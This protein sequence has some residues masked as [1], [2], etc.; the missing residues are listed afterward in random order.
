MPAFHDLMAAIQ[1]GTG[2]AGGFAHSI[3]QERESHEREQLQLLKLLASDDENKVALVDPQDVVRQG[4]VSFLDRLYGRGALR[5]TR[6]EQALNVGGLHFAIR[7]RGLMGSDEGTPATIPAPAPPPQPKPLAPL[8]PTS[9]ADPTSPA[10]T[11][12]S[13]PTA[14]T[15]TSTVH[16]GVRAYRT[17]QPGDRAQY[18]RLIQTYAAKYN[19]PLEDAYAI[20]AHESA[21]NQRA[22]GKAGEVGLMQLT[23]DTAQTLGVD[24]TN[25]EQNIEGGLRYYR[26]HLDQFGGNR[27]LA[28][29][30]YNA[31]PQAVAA[32]GNQVPRDQ[33]VGNTPAYVQSV[34]QAA[35]QFRGL[36]AGPGATSPTATR[37]A[38]ATSTIPEDFPQAP[39]LRE[40]QDARVAQEK[41]RFA[42]L[43]DT[44]ANRRAA[45]TAIDEARTK[46]ATEFRAER[47]AVK[48]EVDSARTTERDPRLRDMLD[49]VETE[50]QFRYYRALKK[51]TP[52]PPDSYPTEAAEEKMREQKQLAPGRL[53]ERKAE[54]AIQTDEALRRQA[55]EAPGRLTERQAEADI[56]TRAEQARRLATPAALTSPVELAARRI[57]LPNSASASPA[58]ADVI[59]KM[60]DEDKKREKLNEFEQHKELQAAMKKQERADTTVPPEK[61]QYYFDRTTLRPFTH[62]VTWG[63]LDKANPIPVTIAQRKELEKYIPTRALIEEITELVHDV[64]GPG[65]SLEALTQEQ[66]FMGRLAG[67]AQKRVLDAKQN[68][69]K[70][71]ILDERLREYGVQ[72]TKVVE[73]LGSRPAYPLLKDALSARPSLGDSGFFT[74]RLPDTKET[75]LAQVGAVERLIHRIT[76]DTLGVTAPTTSPTPQ[77]PEDAANQAIELNRRQRAERA[78]TP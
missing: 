22:T 21:F 57:G 26:Q 74:T 45:S 62:T 77:T 3:T 12:P 34:E 54:A 29:A 59:Q 24:P 4:E 15:S 50:D 68:D 53:K 76:A 67:A 55:L 40:V 28:R 13:T 37:G 58:Q 23:P 56:Q 1:F 66:G 30:A 60:V 33:K 70:V 25:L 48:A 8:P 75:I 44:E 71:R 11:T 64:F 47:A 5:T 63:E 10:T 72:A 41:R 9:E 20:V 7:K 61:L 42:R 17:L 19:I 69:P 27:T 43:Y 6:G 36:F 38:A 52:E 14:P 51:V 65:G 39:S 16:P 35:N 18:D 73:G 46:A 32:A 49:Q 78:A 31:G 2:L